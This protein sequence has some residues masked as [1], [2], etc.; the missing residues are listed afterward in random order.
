[1]KRFYSLCNKFFSR[2]G[3]NTIIPKKTQKNEFYT[4]TVKIE[5]GE[6]FIKCSNGNSFGLNEFQITQK[7]NEN[8]PV[9]IG[10]IY[11]SKDKPILTKA[12][13]ILNTED[14]EINHKR[15]PLSA[16]PPIVL[17]SI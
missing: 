9:I 3:T 11:W 10:K 16:P 5:K 7:Y 15:S 12:I 14:S 6:K 8:N 4:G 17:T 2:F 13:D 1:M